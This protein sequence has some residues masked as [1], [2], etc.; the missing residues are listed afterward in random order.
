MLWL[1]CN[2]D[3]QSRPAEW[4]L[5]ET[6]DFAALHKII[7]VYWW[8]NALE[9]HSQISPT[10][11]HLHD[12]HTARVCKQR[13]AVFSWRSVHEKTTCCKGFARN[14]HTVNN[15]TCVA[16]YV[17]MHSSLYLQEVCCVAGWTLH[18]RKSSG[19]SV[20]QW[21]M[22]TAANTWPCL[23]TV[24]SQSRTRAERHSGVSGK[25]M[26]NE[27]DSMFIVAQCKWVLLF[28]WRLAHALLA[29]K[30]S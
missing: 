25:E 21:R 14:R 3:R 30:L 13:H 23:H 19:E 27:R 5:E 6:H 4:I 17:S 15:S 8:G 28:K 12:L 16:A 24:T 9:W 26:R 22:K 1:H 7:H 18:K 20:G 29:L 2:A 10:Q 11:H